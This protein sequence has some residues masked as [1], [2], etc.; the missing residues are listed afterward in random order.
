MNKISIILPFKENF[1]PTYAGAAS[2]HVEHITQNSK[3]KKIFMFMVAQSLKRG[4]N[5]II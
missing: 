1:S 5:L 3:Y 4:S 2:L